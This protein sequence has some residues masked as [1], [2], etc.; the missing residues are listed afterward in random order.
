MTTHT[1]KRN[2]DGSF[3]IPVAEKPIVEPSNIDLR[4]DAMKMKLVADGLTRALI[5]SKCN[6][7]RSLN[8]AIE[9]SAF[10]LKDYSAKVP[11]EYNKVFEALYTDILTVLNKHLK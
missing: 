4:P 9:H 7:L 5:G 10:N 6:G 11:E 1:Y 3:D 2:P 8:D